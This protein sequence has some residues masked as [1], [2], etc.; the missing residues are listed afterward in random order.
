MSQTLPIV[1]VIEPDPRAAAALELLVRDWGYDCVT[2][3][4]ATAVREVLSACQGKLAAVIADPIAWGG[5]DVGTIER[6]FPEHLPVLFTPGFVDLAPAPGR[7]IL[8][9]PFDPDQLLQWLK[10]TTVAA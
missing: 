10:Q 8:S 4:D 5:F 6:S 7:T 1:I 3:S 9:K 2:A